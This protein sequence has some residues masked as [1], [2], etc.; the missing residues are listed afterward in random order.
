MGEVKRSR[1]HAYAR[2]TFSNLNT[3]FRSYFGFCVYFERDPLPASFRTV[4]GYAQ[5]L[6]RTLKPQ[7]IRNYLS[8]VKMLHIFLGYEYKFSDDFHLQLVLRGIDRLHPHVP[9][10]AKPVTPAVLLLFHQYMDRECSLHWSVYSCAL[11]LFFTLARLGSIL[12]VSSASA[13]D[14]F[15]TGDCV[16]FSREGMLITML[17]TK[18]IQFGN[19]RLHV[20]LLSRESDLC[21]VRAFRESVTHM[22]RGQHVPAFLFVGAGGV[23]WLTRSIFLRTFRQV[24]GAHGVEDHMAYTG[25]SFRRGGASWAFSVGIPGE[26]IQICGDWT[27]D[28]YKVYLEFSLENKLQLAARFSSSLP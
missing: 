15:L 22:R 10:R 27:S 23:R 19:R 11:V 7:S 20:P 21:P 12:P 2:G 6:S 1:D 8:G 14:T 13:P 26:L 28:A 18:T 3:Q 16:N 5:F 17:H 9:N 4:S 24:L 25:H